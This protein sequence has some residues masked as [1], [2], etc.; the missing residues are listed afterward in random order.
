MKSLIIK[1]SLFS[2][3]IFGVISKADNT[4]TLNPVF[5]RVQLKEFTS[6]KLDLFP[7]AG[8]QLI[9][10]FKLDNQELTPSFKIRLTNA[11]GFDVPT[12]SQQIKA[13][14][15]G[16][17]TIT[18]IGKVN[19][20]V[21]SAKYVS[22]LFINIGGYNLSISLKTTHNPKKH[23]S[24]IIF[25]L[26]KKE[27]I[28]LIEKQVKSRTT[29]LEKNYN[30]KLIAVD[31]IAKSKSLS[32]VA[33]LSLIEPSSTRFKE[34]GKVSIDK[35]EIEVYIDKLL[36]YENDYQI[37]LFE[38]DNQSNTNIHIEGMDITMN[39]NE[40]KEMIRGSHHCNS[41]LKADTVIKCAFATTS[42]TIEKSG[43]LNLSLRTNIGHGEFSW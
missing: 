19:S 20:T 11:N 38:I 36:T 14:L 12:D 15:T 10:P 35:S 5:K 26:D 43:K 16:Q 41:K 6:L 23:L 25:D 24:N 27:R 34:S 17:N 42:K 7:D 30:K 8:T 37:L 39:L 29:A 22:N 33:A 3:L 13:L 28:H 4:P 21:P 32:H 9:F 31:S 2:G 18:I 1:I 40:E